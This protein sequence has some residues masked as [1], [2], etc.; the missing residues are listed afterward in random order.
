MPYQEATRLLLRQSVLDAMRELLTEKDWSEITMADVA[1]AAGVSR[2][3]L[4]NEFKS[5]Q[6]L[7]ESYAL[8]L[9][10]ELVDAVNDAIYAN[11]GQSRLAL[12]AG[13]GSFFAASITDPL[14]QSLLRGE[15]KPDLLRIITTD[16]APIIERSSRRLA[17]TFERSWVRATAADA[18]I[19]SRGVVRLAMSYIAMPPESEANVAEDLGALLG[20]FLDVALDGVDRA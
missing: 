11:E 16:S 1:V 19:L 10:D 12:L 6:G 5:R 14:V 17:E 2:Q 8:R 4:Y 15:A 9:A 7:A 3:T 13:F 18:G 20:P